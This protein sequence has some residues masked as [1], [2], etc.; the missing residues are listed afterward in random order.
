[1]NIGLIGT[2][3]MGVPLA[4]RFID[5]GYPLVVYNRT[6]SKLEPLAQK[7]A[8]ICTTP[9]ETITLA[10]CIFL[11]L[12]DAGAIRN[13]LF[14]DLTKPK[15]QGKTI[16]Q[17]GTI[18]PQESQ[19][20][21]RQI[22]ELGGEYLEA[23]VLGSIPEAKAG[24]LLVMVGAIPEQF[25]RYLPLFQQLGESPRLIGTVGKAAALKLAL[26]QLIGSLTASF[27]QSLGY[28]QQ[29]GVDI[30]EFMEIVRSSAL[31]A[32]TFDK[33]LPRMLD[34]DYSNPNFPTKHLLKD[35]NLFIDSAMAFG[36]NIEPNLGVKQILELAIS[37]G[38]GEGDYSA[39]FDAVIND[40]KISITDES[41]QLS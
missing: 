23:P 5:A 25:E 2:G 27:A 38:L 11:M 19:E 10:A 4:T 9:E 40:T 20:I 21:N 36:I 12:T 6:Q 41:N 37:M 33:K 3:L 39:L 30:N 7:G 22:I 18:S 13:V 34:R 16:V 24:K 14:A 29:Q 8:K 31:Y 32:P 26:N 17:M 15:L 28:L 35:T 1:M